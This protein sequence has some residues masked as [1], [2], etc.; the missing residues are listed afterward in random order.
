MKGK[1]AA[2]VFSLVGET[3]PT[4]MDE[5]IKSLATVYDA[6]LTDKDAVQHIQDMTGS[7]LLAIDKS[8]LIGKFKVWCMQLMLIPR[9]LLPL[10]IY[11]VSTSM[12]E[13]IEKKI[14]TAIRKRLGV[15]LCQSYFA[16]LY[17]LCTA[18][19]QR[20]FCPSCVSLRNTKLAKLFLP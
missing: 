13:A 5:P 10:L 4:M 7:S 12:V 15:L 14:S 3:I 6:S 9:L 11:D 2:V 20:L 16:V 18:R 17:F 19:R 8:R 1:V